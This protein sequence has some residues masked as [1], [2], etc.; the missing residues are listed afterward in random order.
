MPAR[1]SFTAFTFLVAVTVTI[2]GDWL[3]DGGE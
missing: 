3:E 2:S 1:N